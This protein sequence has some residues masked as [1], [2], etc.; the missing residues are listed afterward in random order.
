MRLARILILATVATLLLPAANGGGRGQP[1]REL[2]AGP[3][4]AQ[5]LPSNPGVA[6]GTG[7]RGSGPALG[8]S[9]GLGNPGVRPY[10]SDYQRQVQEEVTQER[11]LRENQLARKYAEQ[12]R[13]EATARYRYYRER[14]PLEAREAYQD[15]WR[16]KEEQD[17]LAKQRQR[18]VQSKQ[19]RAKSGD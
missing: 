2:A 5:S 13:Q 19:P 18:I 4:L 7:A 14:D 11:L 1:F 8:P 9:D 15:A 12:M 6:P 16:W 17:R 3:A 10:Q